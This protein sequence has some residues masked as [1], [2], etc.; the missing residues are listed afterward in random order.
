[1]GKTIAPL[2]ISYFRPVGDRESLYDGHHTQAR[3]LYYMRCCM[4]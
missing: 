1:M 3:D 4:I 2:A